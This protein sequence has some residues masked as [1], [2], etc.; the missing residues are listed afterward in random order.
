ML[1]MAAFSVATPAW[2][3]ADDNVFS[4]VEVKIK[5][6][7]DKILPTTLLIREG[8]SLEGIRFDCL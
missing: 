7:R 3:R 1:L 2:I 6:D 4:W 8:Q 5:A